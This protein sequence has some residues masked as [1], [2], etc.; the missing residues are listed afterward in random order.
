MPHTTHGD[1]DVTTGKP[2][3]TTVLFLA[4]LCVVLGVVVV[5]TA[6]TAPLKWGFVAAATGLGVLDSLLPEPGAGSLRGPRVRDIARACLS[7]GFVGVYL[8]FYGTG[9]LNWVTLS[10]AGAVA[11]L[12]DAAAS[13]MV[14]R[15]VKQ[16][17]E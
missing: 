6:H 2:R 5:L 3:S 16:R 10:H 7:F 17:R 14:K 4:S 8:L 15:V 9:P 13:F 12:A 1:N 11:L